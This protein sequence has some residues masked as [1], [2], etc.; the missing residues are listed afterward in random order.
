MCE[1][2]VQRSLNMHISS[3]LQV[4]VN[5]EHPERKP[6]AI[7]LMTFMALGKILAELASFAAIS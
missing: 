5:M 6:Q 2:C 1:R 3:N 7:F 4:A